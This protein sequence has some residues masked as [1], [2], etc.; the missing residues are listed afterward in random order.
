MEKQLMDNGELRIR[1][2]AGN[3]RGIIKVFSPNV[4]TWQNSH[5]HLESSETYFVQ[6]G[7][8][9]PMRQIKNRQQARKRL[10]RIS[11]T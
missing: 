11:T 3:G 6:E 8:Y 10:E 2:M 5:Y 7:L 1:L 9:P 4:G